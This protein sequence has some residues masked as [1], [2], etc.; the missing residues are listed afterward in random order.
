METV[1]NS[2]GFPVT[3]AEHDAYLLSIARLSAQ[4]VY[5]EAEIACARAQLAR[6]KSAPPDS[7]S[8]ERK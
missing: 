7:A 6:M 8:E 3:Q 4:I 2:Q 5:L 1:I